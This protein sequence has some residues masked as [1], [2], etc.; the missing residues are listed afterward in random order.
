MDGRTLVRTVP[1][2]GDGGRDIRRHRQVEAARSRFEGGR[3]GDWLEL[4]LHLYGD[5]ILPFD[6]PPA[7]LSGE[8]MDRARAV[9]RV[10]GFADIAIAA[11]AAS[12]GL[13]ILTRNLRHF[14]PLGVRAIDP[15]DTPPG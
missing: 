7:R 6:V 10:P 13:T 8:L 11:T 5:R 3:L 12:R 15:F 2:G 1:V 4:V 14:V 9:G